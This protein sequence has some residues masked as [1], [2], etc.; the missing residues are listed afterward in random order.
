MQSI[1]KNR[2]YIDESFKELKCILN[3]VLCI[4]KV[5]SEADGGLTKSKVTSIREH[6]TI[7]NATV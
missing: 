7:I 3:I 4:Y 2:K 1:S 6:Y 5:H